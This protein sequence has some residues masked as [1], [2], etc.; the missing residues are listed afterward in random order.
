[1]LEINRSHL[2]IN[3]NVKISA[4]EFKQKSNQDG[5]NRIEKT[6]HHLNQTITMEKYSRAQVHGL[7]VTTANTITNHGLPQQANQRGLRAC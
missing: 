5:S 7:I 2:F 3:H 4:L 1:M 6:L